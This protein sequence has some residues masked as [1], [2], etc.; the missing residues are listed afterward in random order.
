[1]TGFVKKLLLEAEQTDLINENRL[2]EVKN[3]EIPLREADDEIKRLYSLYCKLKDTRM[4]DMAAHLAE[5]HTRISSWERC[6]KFHSD[7]RALERKIGALHEIL[8]GSVEDAVQSNE[9]LSIRKGWQI[10]L[11]PEG[12]EEKEDEDGDFAGLIINAFLGS[13]EDSPFNLL[14]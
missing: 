6:Q 3:G 1:M 10:V 7:L 4:K 11:I 8:W 5:H 14:H 12:M 13:G 2:C 9:N